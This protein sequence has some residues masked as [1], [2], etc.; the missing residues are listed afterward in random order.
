MAAHSKSS[1]SAEGMVLMGKKIF[2]R[3][4][5]CGEPIDPMVKN[6]NRCSK[7]LVNFKTQSVSIGNFIISQ[8]SN[9]TVIKNTFTGETMEVNIDTFE[10]SISAF[11]KSNF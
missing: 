11:Y 3:V 2:S 1:K 5:A 4:C 7:C 6:Q 8:S 9:R 10:K